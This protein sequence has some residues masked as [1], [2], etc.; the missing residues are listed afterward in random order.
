MIASLPFVQIEK[1]G[2]VLVELHV[3]PN[4]KSTEACGLHAG[5]LRVRLNAPPV[6]GKANA[7]VVLW[8]SQQLGIA[9]A[10]ISLIRGQTSRRKTVRIAAADVAQANWAALSVPRSEPQ[11]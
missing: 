4:A 3:V 6:D 9:R 5:A 11:G 7:A 2:S 8:L 1:Q 10:S